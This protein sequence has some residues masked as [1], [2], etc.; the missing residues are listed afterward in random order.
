MDDFGSI[1]LGYKVL[2]QACV[3]KTSYKVVMQGR[4]LLAAKS[5]LVAG[6]TLPDAPLNI[7]TMRLEQASWQ[8]L[9]TIREKEHVVGCSVL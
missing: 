9:A 2:Q 8:P 5:G 4:F 6:S 7:T 1:A 3:S